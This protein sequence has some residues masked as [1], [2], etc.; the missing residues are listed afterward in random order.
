LEQ[1]PETPVAGDE[2][3]PQGEEGETKNAEGTQEET[4][5][6]NL[7]SEDPGKESADRDSAPSDPQPEEKGR[8]RDRIASRVGFGSGWQ[9]EKAKKVYRDAPE[10]VKKR[11][12]EGDLTTHGAYLATRRIER[13][14]KLKENPPETPEG[15]YGIIYADPPWR[16]DFSVTDNRKVE[17]K[18]PTMSLEDLKKLDIPAADDA[19][20]FLWVPNP[21]LKEGI[22]LLEAWGFSYKTNIVWVKDKLGM[23]YWVRGMHELLLVG[24]RGNPP[25]PAPESR[26][27]SVVVKAKRGEHSTKPDELYEIIEQML[28]NRKP[29]ELFARRKRRGWDSW[30]NEV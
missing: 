23:G 25:R 8:K 18:Y 6:D 15:E 21:K 3:G 11:W 30:G 24:T 9:Y 1:G 10:K 26:L 29:I 5:A 2:S 14:R 12:E 13:E 19:V 17:N 28:P 27:S 16:Y 4:P 22:E 7:D 20:L